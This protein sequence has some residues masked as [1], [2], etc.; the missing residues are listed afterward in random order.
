VTGI[1]DDLTPPPLD[2]IDREEG[3]KYSLVVDGAVPTWIVKIEDVGNCC[4]A[5]G[6][7]WIAL[8]VTVPDPVA[9]DTKALI[10]PWGFKPNTIPALQW[11]IGLVCA[12]KNHWG[13]TVRIQYSTTKSPSTSLGLNWLKPVLKPPIFAQG[14]ASDDCVKVWLRARKLNMITSPILA[15]ISLGSNVKFPFAPTVT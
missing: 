11:D 10:L 1:S 15:S 9:A 7:V 3:A 8:V 4:A 2:R 12:Q 5:P 14:S 13:S 6:K